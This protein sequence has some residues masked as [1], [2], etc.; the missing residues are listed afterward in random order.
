MSAA[1]FLKLSFRNSQS[2][3]YTLC[4]PRKFQVIPPDGDSSREL[5]PFSVSMIYRP[6]PQIAF[7]SGHQSTGE[8]KVLKKQK[9][10]PHPSSGLFK[11]FW[12]EKHGHN[13]YKKAVHSVFP[14]SETSPPET[15][16]KTL[17]LDGTRNSLEH[18]WSRPTST[19]TIYFNCT[20]KATCERPHL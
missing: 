16:R 10:F 9:S 15:T 14:E 18:T 6:A 19:I 20:E 12:K 1:N 2:K 11:Y 3:S 4:H 17:F 8:V 7:V 13:F 5:V